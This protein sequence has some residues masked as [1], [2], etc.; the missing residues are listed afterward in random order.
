[1][2][3]QDLHMKI[4][5]HEKGHI[6]HTGPCSMGPDMDIEQSDQAQAHNFTSFYRHAKPLD[7]LKFDSHR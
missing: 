7:L 1:M 6:D 3:A 5:I 4:Y 2:L